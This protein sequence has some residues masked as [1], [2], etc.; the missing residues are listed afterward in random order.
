M[1]NLFRNLDLADLLIKVVV[2]VVVVVV[3][4]GGIF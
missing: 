2:V 4:S 1:K 3:H